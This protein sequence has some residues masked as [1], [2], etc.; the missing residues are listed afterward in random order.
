MLVDSHCH[1]DF[2][3]F[4]AELPD[5]VARAQAAGVAHLVTISTRVRAFDTIRAI[6]ERFDNVSC[7]VGTHPHYAAEEL[8]VTTADLVALAAHPKVVAIGEV[9]LDYH[10]ETSPRA[11]QEQGF[12]AH[13]AAAR[14]T[15]LPLVIH[16][17]DADEDTA[18]ILEEET[19]KGAFPFLLH[20]FTAGPELARRALALGGYISFSGVITFKKTQDLR[21]IAASVPEDRILVETDSPYLA[22]VPHRGQRNEPSFVA[23]T[24]KVLAA[25]RGVS[26]EQVA[27]ATTRNFRRLFSKAKL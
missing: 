11:A 27:D 20:C 18:A 4:A 22:P 8:D 6:A 15:G 21:A 1:L 25:A 17:R 24:A 9:G 7:S 14:E 12:R 13:I 23:E 5:V 3:D 10:Y 19:A 2:P 26:A 16:A